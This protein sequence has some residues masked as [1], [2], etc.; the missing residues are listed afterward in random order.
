MPR[1]THDQDWDRRCMAVGRAVDMLNN[2]AVDE[3][4]KGVKLTKV[5]FKLDADQGTSVLAILQGD[6]EDGS[7]VGFV[8][9]LDLPTTIL[10]ATRK[11]RGAAVRWRENKPWGE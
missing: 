11:V 7:V 4:P 10:A 2:W 6:T 9:G 3:T 1:D 5:S 8:G